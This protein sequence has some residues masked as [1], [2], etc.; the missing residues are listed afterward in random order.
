M[1]LNKFIAEASGKSRREA[2]DLI[3]SGRITINGKTADLGAR[4]DDNDS[5]KLDK[6]PLKTSWLR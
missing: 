1:R 3:M 4:V 5:V 6:S 2:D